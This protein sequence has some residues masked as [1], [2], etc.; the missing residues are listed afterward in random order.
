MLT[1]ILK[2]WQF[3]SYGSY[4][5]RLIAAAALLHVVV[6]VGLFVV[7][8]SQIAPSLIDRDGIMESLAHDSYDYRREALGLP[9]INE[10]DPGAEPQQPRHAHVKVLALEFAIFGRFFGNTILSAEPFNL[11][12]YVSILILVMM[13]GREMGIRRFAL[14][15]V[16]IVAVWPTFLLHST[17]FLKDS[18][19]IALALALILIVTTWLTR[20]Y[21]WRDAVIYGLALSLTSGLLLLIRLKFAGFI[22]AIICAGFVCL[23]IRQV[24]QAR[25]LYRNLICPVLILSVTALTAF[26]LPNPDERFKQNPSDQIGVYKLNDPE[27]LHTVLYRERTSDKTTMTPSISAKVSS[28]AGRALRGAAAARFDFSNSYRGSG[29]LIDRDV[30]FN[31][32]T[33]LFRYLPRALAIGLW[34]PFP[35]M[36]FGPG[37]QVGTAGRLLSGAETLVMYL[38]ELLILVALWR[39]RADLANWL[40]LSIYTLGVTGLGLIVSNVGALY[41]ARYLF[42]I[43]LIIL[44]VKSLEGILTSW[45]TGRP[46]APERNSPN[47]PQRAK[48]GNPKA[49]KGLAVIAILLCVLAATWGFF[50]RSAIAPGASSGVLD[51]T[52]I[53]R[54][55]SSLNG[56]YLSPHDSAVWQENVLSEQ[57]LPNGQ[58]VTIRFSPEQQ[59]AA[60][61]LRVEVNSKGGAEWKNLSLREISKIILR[62]S[63]DEKVFFAEIE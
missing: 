25:L 12:S 40:W 4:G 23:I 43:L 1:R 18:P 36:W 14:V 54:T 29:S 58:M 21:T 9:I 15:A 41:R 37:K 22:F 28:L 51:F 20:T 11:L 49:I 55:R 5:S 33:D 62:V 53:N 44:A 38:V 24:V 61:D 57:K 10:D 47:S 7:G 13:L 3:V 59:P 52:L 17:Q 39:A 42:L 26:Y 45:K 46:I 31:S 19:F 30:Y 27:P 48:R 8:R 16:G 60:W 56:I 32:Y 34:A 2:G 63:E 50:G 6:T 35:N